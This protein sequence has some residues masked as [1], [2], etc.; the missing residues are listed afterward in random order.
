MFSRRHEIRA[1]KLRRMGIRTKCSASN[2]LGLKADDCGIDS[3]IDDGD[4]DW[5]NIAPLI[6]SSLQETGEILNAFDP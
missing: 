6:R 1:H 3:I 5:C 2:Y 4:F